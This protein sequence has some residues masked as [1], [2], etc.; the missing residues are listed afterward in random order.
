MAQLVDRLALRRR[1]GVEATLRV[2]V[3]LRQIPENVCPSFCQE[4]TVSDIS[5]ANTSL[6]R[7]LKPGRGDRA[8]SSLVA[9]G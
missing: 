8:Y 9:W 4:V 7:L 6:A 2:D 1:D 3:F 5:L